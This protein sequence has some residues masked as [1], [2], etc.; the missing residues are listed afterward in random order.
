MSGH[1]SPIMLYLCYFTKDSGSPLFGSS[2]IVTTIYNIVLREM[3]LIPNGEAPHPWFPIREAL[4]LWISILAVGL[5][6]FHKRNNIHVS[7][8]AAPSV[9]LCGMLHL[10]GD[11]CQFMIMLY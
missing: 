1:V 6:N 10:Q 3:V 4:L 8:V 5:Y 9:A 11:V 7:T 2:T